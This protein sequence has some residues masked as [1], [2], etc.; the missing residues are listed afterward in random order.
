[1]HLVVDAM[2]FLQ[3]KIECRRV[4]ESVVAAGYRAR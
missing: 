4:A 3:M 2:Y 1:M